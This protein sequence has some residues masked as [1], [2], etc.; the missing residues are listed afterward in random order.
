MKKARRRIAIYALT[1]LLILGATL[2]GVIDESNRVVFI[3]LVSVFL[4][5]WL[6]MVIVNELRIYRS[7]QK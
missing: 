6:A 3:I 7:E 5:L 2:P 4:A 1:L